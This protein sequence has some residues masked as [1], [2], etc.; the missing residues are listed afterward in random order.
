MA[1]RWLPLAMGTVI[2]GFQ[3]L[4]EAAHIEDFGQIVDIGQ[5]IQLLFGHL[6]LTPEFGFLLDPLCLGRNFTGY[7]EV[8]FVLECTTGATSQKK[9]GID[10][11]A[12]GKQKHNH[13]HGVATGL[14]VRR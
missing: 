5:P 8:D 12:S 3:H 1:I 11:R 2:L 14:A 4:L 9:Q 7:H 13:R 6:Q 10:A